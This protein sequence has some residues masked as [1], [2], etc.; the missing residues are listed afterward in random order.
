MACA[1]RASRPAAVR[2]HEAIYAHNPDI[3]CIMTAQSPNATA[4][5][6]T[7][8]NFDSRTIPESFIMLRDVPLVAFKTLYTQPETVAEDGFAAYAG[9]AGG[10]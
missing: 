7:A 3:N 4:Y 2:L 5:A 9:A 1:K 10:K 6:I 8:A